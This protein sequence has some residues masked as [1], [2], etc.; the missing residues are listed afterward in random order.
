MSVR[1]H[2]I[3]A[4]PALAASGRSAMPDDPLLREK[5]REAIR[6]GTLPS[7]R[8]DGTLGGSGFG[9]ACA[10]C[11][12]LLRRDQLELA[13]V[14]ESRDAAPAPRNSYHFHP[15]CYLVWEAERTQGGT[16]SSSPPS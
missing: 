16:V 2:G 5:A 14:F 3:F 15:L 1:P 9:G 11:G 13:A 12:E 6:A 10:L 4:G 7:R 8:P